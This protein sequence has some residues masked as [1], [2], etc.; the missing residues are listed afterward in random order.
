MDTVK[1]PTRQDCTGDWLRQ[2]APQH[3]QSLQGTTAITALA[4]RRHNHASRRYGIAA[5]FIASCHIAND[6]PA[7]YI[8]RLCRQFEYKFPVAY[9]GR[10]GRIEFDFGLCLLHA[11]DAGLYLTVL[12]NRHKDLDKL[13]HAVG[14]HF[15][16]FAWQA[17]L[18]LAWQSPQ[19]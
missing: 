9:D 14:S 7:L 2:D 11:D 10:Q 5:P 4:A 1:L 8:E 3:R 12:S 6:A 19:D 15:E 16:R 18:H 13:K 17:P